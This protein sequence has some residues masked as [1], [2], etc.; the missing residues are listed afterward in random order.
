MVATEVAAEAM[1]KTAAS[2]VRVIIEMTTPN[3]AV[4]RGIPPATSEP[5]VTSRTRRATT[6]PT[7]SEF[8]PAS[9]WG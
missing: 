2:M 3:R 8:T 9:S 6:M 4:T 5:K 7:A 1:S